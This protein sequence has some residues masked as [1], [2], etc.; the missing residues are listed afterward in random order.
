LAA[1]SSIPADHPRAPE[2]VEAASK[3]PE[4]S[5]G[6][7]TAAYHRFRLTL[8]MGRV[9]EVRR[10]LDL[11]LSKPD[12][13]M[14][15]DSRNSFL[16]LRF[17]LLASFDELLKYAPREPIDMNFYGARQGSD[18]YLD[19]DA[20]SAFNTGLPLSL[21]EEAIKRP[22]LPPPVRQELALSAWC[23]AILIGEDATAARLGEKVKEHWPEL[24]EEVARYEAEKD[25]PSRQFSF[26]FVLLRHPGIVPY[27]RGSLHRETP[28]GRI[29]KFRENWWCELGRGG[30][31]H[32]AVYGRR[33]HLRYLRQNSP[34]DELT[35]EIPPNLPFLSAAE[36]EA[37]RTEL[38]RLKAIPPAPDLLC[39]E[40][41]KWASAHPNDP[42]APQALHLAV[43]A[44]RYG[45]EGDR[46]TEFSRR[47]YR[48]LHRNY[49]SSQWTKATPYWY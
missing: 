8:E 49:P 5:P 43:R 35:K 37:A 16:E 20:L 46:T 14:P 38:A 47:A 27:L 6:Y 32:R 1:I 22:A 26:V 3:L 45:C 2:L 21:L 9:Q 34:V 39:E 40:A 29:D 36:R 42:R 33:E 28:I 44:T 15:P 11:F 17:R 12:R 25:P 31:M 18:K 13:K 10:D 7:V 41:L 48:F 4:S 23:R 24:R 19:D 30:A